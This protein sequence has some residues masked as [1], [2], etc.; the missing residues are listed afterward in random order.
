MKI[1]K[2]L[3]NLLVGFVVILAAFVVI[4]LTLVY[5]R[6][7]RVTFPPLEKPISPRNFYVLSHSMFKDTVPQSMDVQAGDWQKALETIGQQTKQ[8]IIQKSKRFT[9]PHQVYLSLGSYPDRVEGKDAVFIPAGKTLTLSPALGGD[10]VLETEMASLLGD[11]RFVLKVG[12]IEPFSSQVTQASVPRDREGLFYRILGR[13]L[14]VDQPTEQGGR[15][16]AIKRNITLNPKDQISVTCEAK[17]PGGCFLSDIRFLRKASKPAFSQIVFIVV[18]TLRKD[19]V[20]PDTAPFLYSLQKEATTFEHAIAPGNMTSPSTNAL[21]SCQKPTDIA[22]VAFSYSI[23]AEDR[24][25]FY[26]AGEESFPKLLSK[27]GYQTAMLGNISVLSELIGGGVD[28]GFEEEILMEMEGYSTPYLAREAREWIAK[29]ADRPFFLYLHFDAPH[30]P[31]KP[32]L[33]DLK[34]QYKGWKSLSSWGSILEW[35]YAGEVFYTDRYVRKIFEALDHLGLGNDVSFVVTADHGDHFGPSKIAYNS[36][37]PDLYGSYY[38][39]GA[40]LLDDEI[41]VPLIMKIPGAKAGSYNQYVS[42]LDIAPTLFDAAEIETPKW[43]DGTSLAQTMTTNAPRKGIVASEGFRQRAI[44]FEGRYKYIR[45]YSPTEKRFFTPGS[46][47]GFSSRAFVEEALFDLEAD[48]REEN[49]L[50]F[51]NRP[52]LEKAQQLYRSYYNVQT[53]L[54]LVIETDEKTSYTVSLSGQKPLGGEVADRVI[55]PISSWDGKR[56]TVTVGGKE[57]DVLLTSMRLPLPLSLVP[58]LP[59]EHDPEAFLIYPRPNAYLR[60]VTDQQVQKRK[61]VATYPE[62][63]KILREWGY[64]QDQP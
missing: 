7:S 50:I 47:R 20:A 51:R 22:N 31:Y 41:N 48:P 14:E 45:S 9:Y 40:T 30:G 56:I 59:P 52:L 29:N 15:W 26:E 16:L 37:G 39:H 21:L 32:P 46:Y 17:A 11:A 49:N 6:D 36:L 18:D 27:H 64:L 1:L 3:K 25:K 19:G 23:S 24:E 8:Y 2:L 60:K 12:A 63:E 55:L 10:Y 57:V 62:F 13:Y 53:K 28:H 61:I 44:I 35:Q 5:V 58:K 33:Q 38:D 54:E 43:C 4:F 34:A 42:T